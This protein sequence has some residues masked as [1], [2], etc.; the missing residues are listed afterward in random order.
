MLRALD[1]EVIG[2]WISGLSL[3]HPVVD[4]MYL[5]NTMYLEDKM[6]PG[7]DSLVFA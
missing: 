2:L 7:G 4:L 6:N 3:Q 5:E 1:W